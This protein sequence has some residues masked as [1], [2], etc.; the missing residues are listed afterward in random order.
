[1]W[2]FIRLRGADRWDIHSRTV[3]SQPWPRSGLIRTGPDA[4]AIRAII[5]LAAQVLPLGIHQGCGVGSPAYGTIGAGWITLL[6]G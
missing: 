3:L 1:M 2:A 4:G 5:T 6:Y